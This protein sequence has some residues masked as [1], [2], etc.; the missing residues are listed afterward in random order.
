MDHIV[1][2]SLA[3]RPLAGLVASRNRPSQ[4]GRR[5][6]DSGYRHRPCDCNLWNFQV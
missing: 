5:S 2:E 1:G 4:E 6:R 3:D